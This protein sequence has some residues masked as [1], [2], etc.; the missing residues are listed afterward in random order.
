MCGYGGYG[1]CCAVCC[2]VLCCAV[3]V[4]FWENAILLLKGDPAAELELKE[5]GA[6]SVNTLG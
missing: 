6:R 2:A 1:G 3:C 4:R 5:D